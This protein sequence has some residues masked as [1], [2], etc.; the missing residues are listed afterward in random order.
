MNPLRY[1][2]RIT[3]ASNPKE[4]PRTARQ[5]ASIFIANFIVLLIIGSIHLV[6]S[7]VVAILPITAPI[8][9]LFLLVA[10]IFMMVTLFMR[11]CRV[12]AWRLKSKEDKPAE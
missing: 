3:V 1:W 4:M 5:V 6:S 2:T 8:V 12:T 7:I 11:M 9:A 10:M